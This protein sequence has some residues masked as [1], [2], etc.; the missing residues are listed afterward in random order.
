MADSPERSGQLL[1]AIQRAKGAR[2]TDHAHNILIVLQEEEDQGMPGTVFRAYF[3]DCHR[4][5]LRGGEAVLLQAV[6]NLATRLGSS[7]HR[8]P[9][10]RVAFAI[11]GPSPWV[12]VAEKRDRW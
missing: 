9:N 7:T 10:G 5:H 11:A 4:R 2:Q 3:F 6:Q 12:P 8:D 1:H